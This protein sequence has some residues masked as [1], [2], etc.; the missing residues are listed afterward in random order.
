MVYVPR[1]SFYRK[2]I[3]ATK[4]RACMVQKDTKS[5]DD[6]NFFSLLPDEILIEIFG[7][8][9]MARDRSVCSL[10]CKRWVILQSHMRMSDMKMQ[11][12]TSRSIAEEM[13]G[14]S[15]EGSS[16][17]ISKTTAENNQMSVH[18]VK[19]EKQPH[20]ASGDLSRCLEGK[21]ATDIRLASVAV[22]TSAFG[23]LGKLSI[24]GGKGENCTKAVSDLGLSAI[25][26]SCRGL[27]CLLLWDCPNIGDQGLISIG[28]GC[29]LLEKLDLVKC[30][31]LGNGA[32]EAIARGCPL[33]STLSL[34]SCVMI[35]SIGLEA[36]GKHCVSLRS[37]SVS[38]CP[39]IRDEGIV[40][41]VQNCKFLRVLK[42]EKVAITDGGLALV[43]KYCN[44]LIKLILSELEDIS[45][46]GFGAL[47]S[48]TGLENIKFLCITSCQGVSNNSLSVM[49]GVCKN[50]KAFSLV[51]SQKVT[52][53][54]LEAFAML[55][56]SL[57]VLRLERC[58]NIS[59]SGLRSPSDNT[60]GGLKEL[61]LNKCYGLLDS[62]LSSI[63]FLVSCFSIKSISITHCEG[64]GN[65]SL[66][67]IG[68]SCP[69][70]ENLDLSGLFGVSDTG[71]LAFLQGSG[72]HLL[73][74][75]LTGCKNLTDEAVCAIA[76]H[77]GSNLQSLYLEGCE[78]IT[79]KSLRAI[80]EKCSVLQ[81]LDLSKCK[82]TDT[83][84]LAI[85]ATRGPTLKTLSLSGCEYITEECLH[86]IQKVCESLFALNLKGCTKLSINALEFFKSQ[87]WRCDILSA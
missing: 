26:I 27:K 46:E 8:I 17:A 76:S 74:V 33:L 81:D 64:V 58:Q 66:E 85:L 40:A 20:W 80:A 41:V 63:S 23:G 5:S 29:S 87:L 35:G 67:K 25:G 12:G 42:L 21:K 56:G 32:L 57:E 2:E 59:G 48:S 7:H 34:D 16:E 51:D 79:D 73:T 38:K 37:L 1:Q 77:S 86:V 47:G 49:G 50:L 28:N 24:K 4:R 61:H 82:I 19:W 71:I 83:G 3:Q 15:S 36:V 14:S 53:E 55:C 54:G 44:S 69:S 65:Q 60:L 18:E 11:L 10:I 62:C 84:M 9:P 75:N 68:F 43:G 78:K 45:E 13:P 22:G 70:L 30:P 31:Q 72:L 39:A 6:T 52:D